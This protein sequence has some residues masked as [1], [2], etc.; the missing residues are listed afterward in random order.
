MAKLIG[1]RYATSLFEVAKELDKVEIIYDEISF[2]VENFTNNNDFYQFFITPKV[3]KDERKKVI[4]NIYGGK[5]SEEVINFLKLLLDKKRAS[6]IFMI[7]EFFEKLLDESRNIKRVTIE[8][9]IE[10][11]DD[12][13][14]KLI[15]KLKKSI[16]SEIVLENI[17]NPDILGG[18]IMKI[19]NEIID[20]SVL[21]KLNSIEKS[22][23]KII[24]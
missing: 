11:T 9:V 23:S 7:K 10:L 3:S 8:S 14:E 2:I 1:R 18:I 22:I 20:N 24:I 13:K 21:A 6:E 5:I 15:E 16:G 4:E 12:H 17:I 19:D